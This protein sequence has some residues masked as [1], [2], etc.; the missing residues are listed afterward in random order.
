MIVLFDLDGTLIDSTEA[1]LES[2]H[3]A[4]AKFGFASPDD[5]D[6]KRL[7]G[8]PLDYMFTHV[9]VEK[10]RVW[11]YV[12]AYKEHYRVISKEKTHLLPNAKEAVELA[13]T[14]ARLG[15][16][17]TKTARYSKELMDHFGLL[18]HFEVLIGREDVTNPKPHPEPILNAIELMQP[19]ELEEIYMIGDTKLDMECAKEAGVEALGVLC[20]YGEKEELER[21]GFLLFEDS[22]EAM[23]YLKSTHSF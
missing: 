15:I 16:V 21:Y 17:T 1:I 18:H 5:K 10:E 2:F 14:F 20:G 19:K 7:I 23:K 3:V 12:A 11:D 6:I 4:C 8:Y 22:L 13:S 9:G